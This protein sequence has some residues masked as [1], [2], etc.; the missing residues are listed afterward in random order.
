[1]ADNNKTVLEEINKYCSPNSLLIID[2]NGVL[3]RLVCPFKVR[4]II[5]TKEKNKGQEVY[6]LAVKI[7]DELI[8]LYLVDKTLYPYYFFIIIL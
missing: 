7:S 8:L 1:M 3:R 4:V 2:K 5:D 6:V